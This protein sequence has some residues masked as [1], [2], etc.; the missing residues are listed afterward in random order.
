V[1]RWRSALTAGCPGVVTVGAGIEGLGLPACIRQGWT[2]ADI[3]TRVGE[4]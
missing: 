3:V 1:A 4:R 2:A